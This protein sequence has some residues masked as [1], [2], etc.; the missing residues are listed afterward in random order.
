MHFQ[1]D[2]QNTMTTGDLQ[3]A[4]ADLA[5]ESWRFANEYR[6][7][8]SRID[9]NEQARFIGKLNYF[10]R[11]VES[12]LAQADLK[13]VDLKGH[14]YDMGMAA[15]VLN[16]DEY[17]PGDELVIEQML[18]PP[19]IGPTGIVRTGKALVKRAECK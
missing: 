10:T 19:I 6:R 1:A 15:D 18:E 12:C 17:S 7:L 3:T 5:V 14:S 11:R 16:L 9:A 4:L 8:V 2:G 13:L